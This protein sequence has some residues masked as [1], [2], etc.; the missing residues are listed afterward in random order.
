MDPI[1]ESEIPENIKYFKSRPGLLKL[2]QLVTFLNIFFYNL[3]I[4]SRLS[5][6]KGIVVLRL[7]RETEKYFDAFFL[8]SDF[9]N[10]M[11]IFIFK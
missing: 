7:F 5:F 11:C 6:T 10:Y 8:I 1:R 2:A 4:I 3:I 9:G